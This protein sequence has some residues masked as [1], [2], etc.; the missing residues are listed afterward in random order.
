M[1]VEQARQ[2]RLS[3]AVHHPVTVQPGANLD[4]APA[5]NHH[6]GRARRGPGAVEDLTASEHDPAH[7]ALRS[8]TGFR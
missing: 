5:L 7:H 4:D 6:I 1:A 8:T 2:H 3:R